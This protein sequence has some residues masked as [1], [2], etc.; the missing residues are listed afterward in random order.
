MKAILDHL[1][2]KGCQSHYS[3]S[4]LTVTNIPDWETYKYLRSHIK[5]I[6][7]VF[8]IHH[9]FNTPMEPVEYKADQHDKCCFCSNLGGYYCEYKEHKIPAAVHRRGCENWKEN[10]GVYF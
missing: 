8:E 10:E 4:T 2:R 9:V 7:Q 6:M 5:Q 3:D 1:G